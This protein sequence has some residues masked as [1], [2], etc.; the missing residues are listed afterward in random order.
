MLATTAAG[1]AVSAVVPEQSG[2]RQG[3]QV[4]YLGGARRSRWGDGMVRNPPG[5]P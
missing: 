4:A 2:R 5:L 1:R 3:E